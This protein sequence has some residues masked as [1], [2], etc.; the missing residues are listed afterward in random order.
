MPEPT[1]T[2]RKI[3]LEELL[4]LK[5][6][7][8]P[9]AEHW[10]RFD[11]ELNEK[12]WRTLVQPPTRESWLAALWGHRARWMVAGV[13][14]VAAVFFPWTDRIATPVAT[15]R[16]PITSPVL[17]QAA[18]A[19]EPQVSNEPVRV[20]AVL[21]TTKNSDLALADAPAQFAES[22][23]DT[24]MS[25]AGR[26]KVPATVTFAADKLPGIHFASDTL[27]TAVIPVRWRETA[28]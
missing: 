22:T 18:A 1:Q 9:G 26:Q 27:A 3:T 20:A 10:A 12:V 11:R 15:N 25:P 4:R 24:S 16:Q 5:R 14:A 17:A 6:H 19:V 21:S 8:R 2:P 28:Y 13:A 7:E 23:L